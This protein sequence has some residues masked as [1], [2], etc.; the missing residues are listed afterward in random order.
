MLAVWMA[1]YQQNPDESIAQM[2]AT[3]QQ[4]I[5]GQEQISAS[6]KAGGAIKDGASALSGER[7]SLGTE[8]RRSPTEQPP[9]MMELKALTAD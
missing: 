5:V 8:R 3:L 2:I 6:M 1:I 4:T 9:C 7:R